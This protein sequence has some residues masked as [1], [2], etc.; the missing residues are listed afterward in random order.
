[1]MK[2][3]K[4]RIMKEESGSALVLF[5]LSFMVILGIAGLVIDLGIAYNTKS[6]LKKAADAAVLSGA[7]ELTNS[8]DA[9]K[10]VVE[11]ILDAHKENGSLKEMDIMPNGENKLRVALEKDVP[12]YFLKL[13]KVNSIKVSAASAA[14]LAPISR[15]DGAVPLGIDDSIPLVYMQE[16]TLKVD[17][18][19]SSYGNFGIL[20]L[21]GPGAQLYE[22]DLQYGYKGELKVGDIIDTQTGNIEGKTR[23][24]INARIAGCSYTANDINH[25]DCPRIVMILVYKPY[26]VQANQLKQVK[27]TGFAYFYIKQPMGKSDSSITGYFI[28][29]AGTGYGD[30]N[31]R[32]N[33]AYAIKLTE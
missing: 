13:F 18:G 7:Q 31:I 11:D 12:M 9:V 32:D 23:D 14:S 28:R 27:I 26:N 30:E 29:R 5:T 20:A 21:S 25:R 8:S 2:F 16:Y 1:M 10:K 15:G 3:L 33:G 4:S 22:Q 19:D 17:S 24:A 6:H